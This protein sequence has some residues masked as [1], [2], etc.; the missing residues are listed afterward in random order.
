MA[1]E[2]EAHAGPDWRDTSRNPAIRLLLAIRQSLLL[3]IIALGVVLI[4]AG[5]FVLGGEGVLA[6]MFAIWGVSAILYAIGGFL[7]LKVIGYR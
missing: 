3:F 5:A 6:A 4:L 1:Q 2:S 7:F